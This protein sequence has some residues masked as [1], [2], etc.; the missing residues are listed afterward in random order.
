M[1]DKPIILY[2]ITPFSW[3][4]LAVLT[5]FSLIYLPFEITVSVVIGGLLVTVNLL[6]FH[7]VLLRALVPGS[8]VTPKNVLVKYYLRFLG[9]VLIIF[10]LVSQHLVNGLGLIL[11]LSTFILTIFLVLFSEAGTVLYRKITK[12]TA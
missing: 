2:K 9:T 5:V 8:K 11:G 12:E 7:R 10:I 6:L 1:T 4:V 3:I